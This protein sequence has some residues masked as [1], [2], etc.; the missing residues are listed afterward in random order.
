MVTTAECKARLQGLTEA[1]LVLNNADLWTAKIQAGPWVRLAKVKAHGFTLR[2]FECGEL[3]AVI[4]SDLKDEN[5]L[6]VWVIP[7]PEDP[8]D[9]GLLKRDMNWKPPTAPEDFYF[10]VS[11][12]E[13][14]ELIATFSRKGYTDAFGCQYD[15]SEPLLAAW[16]GWGEAMEGV[17]EV[18]EGQTLEGAAT[19]LK[20]KGFIEKLDLPGY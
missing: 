5:I 6:Q 7:F 19:Y 11:F 1:E 3:G 14:A 15:Q 8:L 12:D 13:E 20:S 4:A 10:C 16:L 17:Y 9:G 2:S 18:P